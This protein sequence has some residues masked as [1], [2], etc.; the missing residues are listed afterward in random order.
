[1]MQAGE[2]AVGHAFPALVRDGGQQLEDLELDQGASA[3]VDEIDRCREEIR[4]GIVAEPGCGDGL[5]LGRFQ[6]R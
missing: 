4:G 3:P 2:G 1:M 5:L 6:L